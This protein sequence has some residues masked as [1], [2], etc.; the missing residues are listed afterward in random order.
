MFNRR[1]FLQLVGAVT[2][3]SFLNGCESVSADKHLEV[4][5]P[6]EMTVFEALHVTG[7]YPAIV[8]RQLDGQSHNFVVGVD[9]HYE[10][11]ELNRYWLFWIN[12]QFVTGPLDEVLTKNGDRLLAVLM[13]PSVLHS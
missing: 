10:Q 9:G 5:S 8:S 7:H 12:D 6:N 13:V 3:G 2:G 4:K 11:P 1:R